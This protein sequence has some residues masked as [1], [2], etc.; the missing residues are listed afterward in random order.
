MSI[1]AGEMPFDSGTELAAASIASSHEVARRDLVGEQSL[2]EA[3]AA[4]AVRVLDARLAAVV[5]GETED[6]LV[7]LVRLR[8]QPAEEVVPTRQVRRRHARPRRPEYRHAQHRGLVRRRRA[9]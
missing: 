6:D 5:I 1:S 8:R 3:V 9:H 7:A 4:H 2:G